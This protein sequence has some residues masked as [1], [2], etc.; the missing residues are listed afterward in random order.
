[1]SWSPDVCSAKLIANADQDIVAWTALRLTVTVA[2][3]RRP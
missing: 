2:V 1:M 3:K